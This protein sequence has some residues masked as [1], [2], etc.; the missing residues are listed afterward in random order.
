M[1]KGYGFVQQKLWVHSIKEVIKDT[2]EKQSTDSNGTTATN[3]KR[4]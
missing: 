4:F 3:E 2:N 1:T